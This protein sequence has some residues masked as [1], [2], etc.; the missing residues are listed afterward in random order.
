MARAEKSLLDNYPCVKGI[1]IVRYGLKDD[2][3]YIK[4]KLAMQYINSYEKEKI[5]GQEIIA[6]IQNPR[7]HILIASWN[8]ARM[9]IMI[10]VKFSRQLVA[11]MTGIL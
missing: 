10:Q 7:P 5:I 1:D 4:K 9:N 6:H 3:R 11:S 2:V 8:C